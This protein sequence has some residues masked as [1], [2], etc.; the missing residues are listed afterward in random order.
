MLCDWVDV[1]LIMVLVVVCVWLR[2]CAMTLSDSL[3][4]AE[5]VEFVAIV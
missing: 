2:E 3:C 1:C 5:H 4:T